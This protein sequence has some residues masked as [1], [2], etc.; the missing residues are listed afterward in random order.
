MITQVP[1]SQAKDIW[2]HACHKNDLP[3]PFVCY[4]WHRIWY[5]VFQEE[6]NAFVLHVNDT[7]LAPFMRKGHKISFSG[8]EEI[9]DYLDVL[10]SSVEKQTAWVEL[11][12]Y[13]KS[14]HITHIHL[15]NIPESSSTLTFFSR[16]PH[17]TLQKEDTT[18]KVALPGTWDEYLSSL[19]RKYRHELE[20]KLR[21]FE[22]EH[23]NAIINESSDPVRDIHIFLTLM[24]KDSAKEKF[25]TDQMKTF[26]VKM[27]GAFSDQTSLLLLTIDGKPAAGTLSFTHDKTYYLYNSGFDRSCC[28]NAGFYLKAQSIKRAIEKGFQEYNF[29]QGS[30]R[31][32]YELGGKDFGVY[33]VD[34]RL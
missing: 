1:F 19:T 23:V 9:A 29:L 10:G 3:V 32:K 27:V 26:F 25:L 24:Q 14:L 13:L 31:Y 20:R 17:T 28:Q 30:E 11:L 16:Q 7:V 22:R 4:D 33:T 5:D 21:K 18:P 6:D 2:L 34:A 8:G 12:S 15:R